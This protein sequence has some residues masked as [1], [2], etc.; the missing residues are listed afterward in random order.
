MLF[1]SAIFSVLFL[2]FVNAIIIMMF[3]KKGFS[4]FLNS[5]PV[6]CTKNFLYKINSK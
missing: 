3:W 2:K 4:K 5:V 1:H 6:A